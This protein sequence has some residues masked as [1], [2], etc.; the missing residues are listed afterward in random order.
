[1]PKVWWFLQSL[2]ISFLLIIFIL[3]LIFNHSFF[4]INPFFYLWF[5]INANSI[6]IFRKYL[7]EYFMVTHIHSRLFSILNYNVFV[8]DEWIVMQTIMIYSTSSILIGNPEWNQTNNNLIDFPNWI[9]RF[10]MIIRNRNWSQMTSSSSSSRKS[11]AQ[12]DLRW[13][14]VS[15]IRNH[16]ALRTCRTIWQTQESTKLQMKENRHRSNWKTK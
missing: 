14:R 9:P 1:M 16:Q 7:F 2:L 5:I 3:F 12:Q 6:S 8:L 13:K 4:M 11:I 10:W 15:R